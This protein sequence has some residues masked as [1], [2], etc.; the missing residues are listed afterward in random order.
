MAA[1]IPRLRAN[2]L[3]ASIAMSQCS[4][5]TWRALCTIGEAGQL[6]EPD[7]LVLAHKLQVQIERGNNMH[8]AW[9]KDACDMLAEIQARMAQ[10]IEHHAE[11]HAASAMAGI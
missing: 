10:E 3:A 8:L 5:P 6:W 11:F 2:D 4:P 7:V 1:R 9:C